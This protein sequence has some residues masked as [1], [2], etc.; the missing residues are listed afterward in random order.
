MEP[1]NENE[2]EYISGYVA[3]VEKLKD[4]NRFSAVSVSFDSPGYIIN[5]DDAE[6]VVMRGFD[7]DG[8]DKIYSIS[9]KLLEGRL[10]HQ[11]WRSSLVQIYRIV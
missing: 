11:I 4:D 3:L 8:A 7:L 10:H 6:P 1:L 2:K 9:D 5:D